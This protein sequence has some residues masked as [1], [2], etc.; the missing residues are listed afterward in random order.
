MS[1]NEEQGAAGTEGATQSGAGTTSHSYHSQTTEKTTDKTVDRTGELL[2]VAVE[3]AREFPRVV[4][5]Q[6]TDP[7]DG[8]VA[9]VQS[10]ADGV[11][12]I[13]PD[14]FDKY[15]VFPLVRKGLATTTRLSSFIELI[16]RHKVDGFTSVF[17][18]EG[19]CP[20][21]RAVIDYHSVLMAVPGR[22]DDEP[23]EH[24]PQRGAHRIDYPFPLSEEWQAWTSMNKVTMTLQEFAAF[25][26]DRIG[27]ILDPSEA[28]HLSKSAKAFIEQVGGTIGSPT[29]MMSISRGIQVDTSTKVVSAAKVETGEVQ[30]G[31]SVEHTDTR[32][33]TGAQVKVPSKFLIA[34]PA[35]ANAS[36]AYRMVVRFRFDTRSGT[37]KFFYE[38]WRPDLVMTDAIDEAVEQVADATGVPVFYGKPETMG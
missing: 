12:A 33:A 9:F 19:D 29:T 3:T 22:G 14:I 24:I 34:I 20:T 6:L 35:F 2:K 7:R 25:I 23:P 13:D 38:L 10:D 8:T 11:Q 32:D 26:E 27:D 16:D 36:V 5:G 37:T 1:D 17:V 31:L 18:Q 4:T 28:E 15:R 30:I 21:M